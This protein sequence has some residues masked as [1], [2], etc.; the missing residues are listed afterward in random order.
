MQTQF[1]C[2]LTKTTDMTSRSK[3]FA[4]DRLDAKSNT[5]PLTLMFF[6][7]WINNILKLNIFKRGGNIWLSTWICINRELPSNMLVKTSRQ[8][9][10]KCDIAS[11]PIFCGVEW[12][13]YPW[14]IKSQA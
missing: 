3:L 11:H 12:A 2:L 10:L 1:F 4:L 9:H 13:K 14:P 7:H 8:H 5:R 6:T